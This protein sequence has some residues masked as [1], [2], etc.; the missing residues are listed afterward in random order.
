MPQ[1]RIE[2]QGVIH[3]FP[4]DFTDQDIQY[5][6]SQSEAQPA[7]QNPP[8]TMNEPMGSM[9]SLIFG[10]DPTT[11]G[12]RLLGAASTVT[13]TLFPAGDTPRPNASPELTPQQE[14]G[15]KAATLA[16]V[17]SVARGVKGAV[18]GM[19]PS[20]ERAGQK[21]QQVMGAAKEVPVDTSKLDPILERAKELRGRGASPPST[22]MRQFM[23]TQE[24][25]QFGP[26]KIAPE[27]MTYG[28]SRDFAVS[29]GDQ[30]AKEITGTN[31]TMKRQNKS[32]ARA[33]DDIN[34]EAAYKAGKGAEYD[35]AMRE[36]RNARRVERV[37]DILK[38]HG[39]KA[40]ITTGLGA[41]GY[42]LARELSE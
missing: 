41:A 39:A 40:A 16:T 24:P 3:E 32:F 1:K 11:F 28:T 42:G 22:S 7:P 34:R 12:Q 25:Q 2:Y 13:N 6:L 5:A 21:F 20:T 17:P 19:L 9:G 36:Y 29:A 26:F 8:K 10:V 30:S 15:A 14:I 27:P 38:K 35:Q 23:K 31:R 33:L 18:K 4:D 37:K